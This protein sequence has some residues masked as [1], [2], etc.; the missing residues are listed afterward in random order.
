MDSGYSNH[1][2]DSVYTRY[3]ATQRRRQQRRRRRQRIFMALL[4]SLAGVLLMIAYPWRRSDPADSTG[5]AGSSWAFG[6][7]RAAVQASSVPASV[8]SVPAFT[9][10]SASADGLALGLLN[11]VSNACPC[12]FPSELE[13][14]NVFDSGNGSFSVR[15][16]DILISQD[17]MEPL[18]QLCAAF[19][20][21]TGNNDLL[22]CAGYRSLE[23]QQ[24]LWD[25]ALANHGIE[26]TRQYFSQP[27]SSEHHTGLAVDFAF[28][29]ADKQRSYEFDG[30]GDSQWMIDH[31]WEYGFVQ[32]YPLSKVDIT[33]ISEEAWHF[34]YV[35]Q[36]HATLMHQKELC[37]E[38]YITLLQAYPWDGEHLVETVAGTEYEIWY[39]PADNIQVPTQG[40][41]TLS[42]DNQGGCIVTTV[43]AQS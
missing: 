37:L 38:E 28:Y 17:V 2:P 27:G 22:V 33:G 6:F 21:A 18:N 41:Y 8:D 26:Y 4:L 42:G 7:G 16:T 30:S 29:Q 20:S 40:T 24:A 11:L 5:S 10:Y 12:T 13:L 36:P 9:P 19:Q 35:G 39:C 1:A 3:A 34:R 25:N 32:R 43:R 31:C 23:E 14:V 15:E